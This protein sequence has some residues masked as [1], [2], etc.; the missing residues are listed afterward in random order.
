MMKYRLPAGLAGA[1]GALALVLG[2]ATQ[3]SAHSAAVVGERCQDTTTWTVTNDVPLPATFQV[4]G[5]VYTLPGGDGEQVQFVDH[6]NAVNFT[7]TWSDGF[8][9]KRHALAQDGDCE[10]PPTTTPPTT[11]PP[12]TVP[13]PPTTPKPP[14]TPP[15]SPPVAP[16][17]PV[18]VS[19][20]P[21]SAPS[22][23]PPA[24]AAPAATREVE[25]PPTL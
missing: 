9:Q 21:P 6:A 3:A 2:I 19:P 22:P 13:Q 14:V 10:V 18:V 5:V 23:Q 4:H 20:G 1:A 11:V 7:V 12:T 15:V 25:L 16:P 17:P 8:T 24:P